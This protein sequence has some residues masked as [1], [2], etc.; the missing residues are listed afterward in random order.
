M[1]KSKLISVRFE[2]A[3]HKKVVNL[4]KGSGMKVP[5]YIRHTAATEREGDLLRKL[6]EKDRRLEEKDEIIE[7]QETDFK[8]LY[9]VTRKAVHLVQEITELTNKEIIISVGNYKHNEMKEELKSIK[10]EK[11]EINT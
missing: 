6:K 5:E 4:A 8:K 7:K 9:K 11:V 10:E 3:D 1:S 2:P